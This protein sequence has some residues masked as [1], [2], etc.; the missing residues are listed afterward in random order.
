MPILAMPAPETPPLWW[1]EKK[2]YLRLAV[3]NFNPDENDDAGQN[4]FVAACHFLAKP[5]LISSSPSPIYKNYRP[6]DDGTLRRLLCYWGR[7]IRIRISLNVLTIQKWVCR[8]SHWTIRAL[9]VHF[10]HFQYQSE[11][12]NLNHNQKASVQSLF[13]QCPN[14]AC[15]H[16]F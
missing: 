8:G 11:P 13:G 5:F 1:E 15:L 2:L 10:I 4:V 6:G 16:Q 14:R 12:V 9:V 3:P 7:S